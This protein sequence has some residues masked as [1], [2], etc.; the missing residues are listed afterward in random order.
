MT[1]KK[2]VILCLIAFIIATGLA[3][4]FLAGRK[5]KYSYQESMHEQNRSLQDRSPKAQ[6]FNA[7]THTQPGTEDAYLALDDIT[8]RAF[9]TDADKEQLRAIL[10]DKSRSAYERAQAA[11][12]YSKLIIQGASPDWVQR[13]RADLEEIAK[14][15][16]EQEL[17]RACIFALTRTL[18]NH[19]SDELFMHIA[20][21]G[22]DKGFLDHD[23]YSGELVHGALSEGIFLPIWLPWYALQMIAPTA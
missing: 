12:A 16:D 21:L 4:F 22:V 13:I 11:S 3:A 9:T 19:D 20:Q 17:G 1:Y 14:T 2:S 6:S 18:S 8:K 7:Y 5:I 10:F 15:T 23:N